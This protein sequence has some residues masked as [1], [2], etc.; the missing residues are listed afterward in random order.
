M[1]Q[2]GPRIGF[3]GRILIMTLVSCIL[4]AAVVSAIGRYEQHDIYNGFLENFR[5]NLYADFDA[6]AKGQVETAISILQQANERHKRGE[7]TLDEAKRQ[8]ADMVRNLKYGKD[9]YFWIDTTD[10]TNVVMLGKAE[11]E[12]KNRYNIQDAKG[13]YLIKEIIKNGSKPEG[14]FTDYWFPRKG[15]TEPKPKRSYSRLFEPF[16]WVIG[17]GNYVDDIDLLV[18]KA[19]EEGKV[20]LHEALISISVSAL[21]ILAAVA[22]FS[23]FYTRRLLR[24]LGAEPVY[25]EEIATRIADGDLSV[26][27]DDAK[28]GVYLAMKG[29]LNNLRLIMNEVTRS[30][31][32]VSSAATQLH[33]N[34]KTTEAASHEVVVQAETVST[35]SEEMAST[36]HEIAA[37]CHSAA[38][39]SSQASAAALSGA[40]IVRNT[41]AGMNRIAGK[42]RDSATVVEQLGDRSDQIGAIVQTIEDIADQTNLLA[43]NAAIEAARAG[44]QGRGFAVVADEVRALAERTTKATREIGQMIKGIQGET[45]Q[46]VKAME[47]GVGEV[48]TGTAEAAKSGEALEEIL[49]QVNGVTMQINQIA[50]AAEEQTATTREISHNILEI[51]EVVQKSANS[52]QEVTLAASQLTNL[53]VEL[54]ELVRR[55][56]L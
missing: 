25:L 12:G 22:A 18:K 28:S 53:S 51:S 40:E 30:S 31:L 39:S 24:H 27:I 42:V 38:N 2:K 56:K 20:H 49:R 6:M 50:T 43:L 47:E 52:S 8:A 10:G 14:G 15:E 26:H 45:R 5:K 37:N 34:A 32:E 7:I 1:A 36:S 41:V 17:T 4:L 48:E 54:Q 21:V 29:M 35:A 3:G 46:A 11:V 33:A 19:G 13:T 44:E 55:F 23:A 9:G 16:G